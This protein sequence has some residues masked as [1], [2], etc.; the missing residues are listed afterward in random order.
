MNKLKTILFGL[1]CRKYKLIGN[2]ISWGKPYNIKGKNNK[3]ILVHD[4]YEFKLSKF[5]R[6]KG[7]NITI[8]GS[9]NIVKIGFPCNFC[10]SKVLVLGDNN[11]FKLDKTKYKIKRTKFNMCLSNSRKFIIGEDFSSES[12]SISSLS[13]NSEII[14]GNDCMFANDVLIRNSD[15]HIIKN[16]DGE[17]INLNDNVYIGNHVWLG[18]RSTVL[19]GSVIPDNCVVG[20]CSLVVGKFEETNVA[21]GG[22][23][24]KVIKR[25]LHW[26]RENS[27][28][29]EKN[30][31]RL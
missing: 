7:L 31:E 23:P 25:D 29:F 9:N 24:A 1:F 3:I 10:K 5:E 15:G 30:K 8:K 12:G 21:L 13:N 16:S 2:N 19:K 6:V 4:K 22:V 26:I 11:L 18:V 20:A 17:I 28:A 14:I 27:Y